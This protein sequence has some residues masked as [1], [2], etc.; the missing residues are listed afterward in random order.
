MDLNNLSF[1]IKGFRNSKIAILGDV[2]LDEYCWGKVERISPEAPVPIVQI[3]EESW[4]LGG[5]ANVASN[6]ASLGGEAYMFSILG[7]D[8]N[9]SKLLR[10]LRAQNI[11]IDGIVLSDKRKTSIKSRIIGQ[12][13]QMMRIDRE[14]I[15]PINYEEQKSILIKIDSIF[16]KLDGIIISDYAKG[17]IVEDL[18]VEIIRKFK[19]NNKFI[20]VD[21][22]QKNFKFY[23]K[24]TVITPNVKEAQEALGR[25][26]YSEEDLL[27]GGSDLL[28]MSE[29]DMILLTR[30]EKGV[31]LFEKDKQP[32]TIPTK[33]LKVYDVTGAGDTVIAVFALG[34]SLNIS[35]SDA[36]EIANI[37]AGIVVG[38]VGTATAK[39]EELIKYYKIFNQE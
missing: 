1:L 31:T 25:M 27:K 7:N 11:N 22:R 26:F 30:S 18:F 15:I 19:S 38:K 32:L 9:A 36:A 2:I 8:E 23:K 39:P 16:D 6:I 37:A 34:L 13:Q 17:I 20:A 35:S 14:E 28:K 5:A 12:N 10:E 4:K 3:K 29:S 21:P 33:A 24:Q